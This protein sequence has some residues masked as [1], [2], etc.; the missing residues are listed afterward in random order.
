MGLGGCQEAR[1]T[2]SHKIIPSDVE[3]LPETKEDGKG[4][5]V[6]LDKEH[7]GGTDTEE[8]SD[9]ETDNVADESGLY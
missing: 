2:I 3:D 8:P 9:Y 7:N 4:G 6:M 5:Y 1:S